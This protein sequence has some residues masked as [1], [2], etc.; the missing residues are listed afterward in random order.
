MSVVHKSGV[1]VRAPTSL[2]K[3]LNFFLCLWI[4]CS[5]NLT[6]FSGRVVILLLRQAIVI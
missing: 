3:T 6:I 2:P 4:W 1:L 5:I